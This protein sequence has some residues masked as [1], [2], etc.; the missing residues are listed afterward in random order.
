MLYRDLGDVKND[1]LELNVFRVSQC[2]GD[3]NWLIYESEYAPSLSAF[4]KRSACKN[5]ESAVSLGAGKKMFHYCGRNF[6][7]FQSKIFDQLSTGAVVS[8]SLFT[9]VNGGKVYK[10]KT[11]LSF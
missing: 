1:T 10:R 5:Q 9:L 3:A 4:Q 7:F 2:F 6:S 11:S 8:S